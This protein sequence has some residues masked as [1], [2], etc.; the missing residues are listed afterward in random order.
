MKN[1]DK[2]GL[3]TEKPNLRLENGGV[4]ICRWCYC[5]RKRIVEE[6]AK[7]EEPV[8]KVTVT[9]AADR[10]EKPAEKPEKK[11]RKVRKVKKVSKKKA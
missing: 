1:C 7:K 4:A 10:V 2:C 3:E 9:K 5:G 11:D 6:V 8:V